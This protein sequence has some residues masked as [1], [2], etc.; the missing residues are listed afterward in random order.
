LIA[1]SL[2][3]LLDSEAQKD[4]GLALPIFNGPRQATGSVDDPRQLL[5][6]RP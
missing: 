4:S 5:H 6:S 1:A 3:I 2:L